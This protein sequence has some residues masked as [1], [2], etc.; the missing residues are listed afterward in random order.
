MDNQREIQEEIADNNSEDFVTNAITEMFSDEEFGFD[1]FI[2]MK[3]DESAI[4]RFLF[5]EEQVE[6]E[7]GFKRRIQNS[8]VESIQTMFLTE[9]AEFTMVE[10]IANNQDK[11][12][13]IQQDE[14]YRPFEILSTPVE[15]I[16]NFTMDESA[17]A[18]AIVFRF[19]RGKSSFWAYQ[20]IAPAAVPN[21][22]KQNFLIKILSTEQTDQFVEMSDQL[23]TITRKVNLLVIGDK[24][25]TKDISLMQRH[26]G[27]EDFVRASARKAVS[28]ISNIHIVANDDKLTDYIER[29]STKY[30]KKMMRIKNYHVIEK[31]AD[32]LIEK[33]NN[34]E[35]WKGVFDIQEGNKINLRTYK[36]VENLIDL[37]D[38]RYTFSLITNDEFDTDVKELAGPVVEESTI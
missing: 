29:T 32:E 33:L 13:I 6:R 27:F 20:Q 28:D 8:I 15:D 3:N 38:E 30:S 25:V 31:S 18:D 37:F 16:N 1:V 7:A 24:I 22:K 34:V 35:R 5:Y 10:N 2:K 11:F 23:F 21:K 9:S 36:D 14:S 26:F 4:K 12:Y 17:E 19:R